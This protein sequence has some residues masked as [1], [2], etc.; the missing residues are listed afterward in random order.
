MSFNAIDSSSLGVT[1]DNEDSDGL[2]IPLPARLIIVAN[3]LPLHAVRNHTSGEWHFEWD[4]DS[5]LLQMKDGFPSKTEIIYVGSLK[6]DINVEE[7]EE[8]S[9]MLLEEFRCVATFLCSHL[10]RSF[11]NGFCKRHLWPL[12]HYMLPISS[13]QSQIFDQ[14]LFRT[15]I[16]ANRIFADKVMEAMN[17]DED[18]VW[19][20]DYHLM[21][22]P[23]LL[24]K[25]LTHIKLGFFLHSPFP[26]SE[27]YKVLPVRDQL[28]KG[29]LNADLIGFQTFEYARH[30]L[31]CCNRLL[32]LDYRFKQGYIVIDYLG[33]IV[34]INIAPV[35]IHISRLERILNCPSTLAKIQEIEQGFKG[36]TIFL[37][38]D[39]MDIFKGISM[40]LLAFEVLLQRNDRLRGKIVLIQ[41]ANPPRTMGKNV[42]ETKM[43]VISLVKG[44][45]DVYGSPGYTPV[46]FIDYSIS[47]HEK[48]AYYVMADCC[49]INALRDGMNL[50]PYEYVV[51]RQGT[52][53]MDRHCLIHEVPKRTSTLIL[54]EFI[55]CSPS[56]SGAIRV[57]PWSIQDVADGL[58]R[59]SWMSA[60][61]RQ[62]HHQKHYRYISSHDVAFWTRG[63]SKELERAC[64]VNANQIYHRLGISLSFRVVSLSPNF[65]KLSISEVV[66]IYKRT[67]NRAI[68][69]D[70]DGTIIPV[71]SA[72]K[73]PSTAL[74]SILNDLCANPG[75]TVFIISGRGRTTL[76]E[77]FCSCT[78]LGIV[79]E[80]GYFIRWTKDSSWESSP[81]F[82]I[83][84]KWKNTVELVM[85]SYTEATDGAY[86]ESKES[87]LVWNHQ[88]ADVEFGS[89]QAKELSNHLQSLL[90][91]AP[92]LVHRGQ[93]IVEVKP[94]G[95]AKGMA[96]EKI[97][98]QLSAN[99]KL[100][101]LIICIGDDR[102]DK[103]MFRSL[104]D[105]V[106]R[107]SLAAPPE[108]FACTVGQKPSSAKYYIEDTD[109]VL[110]LLSAIVETQNGSVPNE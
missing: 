95:V 91:D 60:H 104:N 30:F 86:I 21:L 77:W 71:S 97:L 16:S 4:E 43:E 75:N 88:Y 12:L 61:E 73:V 107:P 46:V 94:Q 79:S 7:Q 22:L 92:V 100:L 19:I 78:N 39:D 1:S 35:G 41:I 85:K 89:C 27:I 64:K 45:N 80:H 101:D 40:K 24:R 36:K 109:E 68:F 54:S 25:R 63:F 72:N 34:T 15:Y 9:Q 29:L 106:A 62:L 102:S 47:P 83:N 81:P 42:M 52:E 32:G 10:Q 90:I 49:I 44:I 31:S 50:V 51:C 53:E 37:G 20:H 57:N 5:L 98:K 67:T 23:T 3:F 87:A 33:R 105:A 74:V 103:N 56:L 38:V 108:V 55:G 82:G 13:G 96:V 59:A 66:S 58:S 11:Y 70:Y 8:L 2:L 110:E 99:G 65:R 26:S 17:S 93:N 84:F 18:Y 69:L 76:D 28:L 6:V 14:T 48:I